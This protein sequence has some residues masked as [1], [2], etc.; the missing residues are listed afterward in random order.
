MYQAIAPVE[1]SRNDF[2]IF[3]ELGDRLGFGAAFTESRDEMAWL[4][5]MYDEARSRASPHGFDPP[6]FDAFWE[7][8]VF[9]FKASAPSPVLL[10]QFRKDPIAHA[11]KTP[12]GRI[13]IF[14][15]V[16]RG[17]DYDD[18]PPHPAWLEP[19]EW[20]GGASARLHPIHL[21]S[22]QPSVRLHSQLDMAPLSRAAKVAGREPIA[23][24]AQAH[25]HA[26]L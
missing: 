18:C 19:A 12:S 3:A 9:E 24:N 13:E 10:G 21:L 17:F 7:S 14:S 4:R 25:R 15:E 22:N 8:G 6:D 2:D 26:A 1:Q 16:V 11:L 20:L 23:L 5:A